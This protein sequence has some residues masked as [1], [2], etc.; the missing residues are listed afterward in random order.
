MD[1]LIP[2]FVV[3]L[4]GMLIYRGLT[5]R[6]LGDG[7]LTPFPQYFHNMSAGFIPDFFGGANYNISAIVLCVLV[8]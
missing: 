7:T 3:T 6:V 8:A 1:R 5:M 2:F 4:A